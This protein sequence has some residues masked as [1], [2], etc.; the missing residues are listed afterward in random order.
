MN[1]RKNTKAG[2]NNNR[3]IPSQILSYMKR[4]FEGQDLSNL[5]LVK[6]GGQV[7]Y[8]IDVNKGSNIYRMKFNSQGLLM[9]KVME[10]VFDSV[11]DETGVGD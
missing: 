10:P 3:T 8:K 6:K 11:F 1:K 7:F 5:K 9:E 4:Y 2:S